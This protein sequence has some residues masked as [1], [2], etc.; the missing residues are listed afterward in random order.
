MTERTARRPLVAVV[1]TA[2][3]L[4]AA[5]AGGWWAS[6]QVDSRGAPLVRLASLVPADVHTVNLT[7]WAGIRDALGEGGTAEQR[8]DLVATAQTRDLSSRSVVSPSA[9]LLDELFGWAP[10][11]IGWEAFVQTPTGGALIIS[12]PESQSMRDLADRLTEVGYERAGGDGDVQRWTIDSA[13]LRAAGLAG[14]GVFTRLAVVPGERIAVSAVDDASVDRVLAVIDGRAPALAGEPLAA[15]VLAPL[16][17][18]VTVLA[19]TEE[20]ACGPADPA[21]VG[22]D[23]RAQADAALAR[24]GPLTPYR[25][26]ARAVA[27]DG[28]EQQMTFAFGFD[29]AGVAAEQAAVRQGLATGPFIGRTGRVD[30]ALRDGTAALRGTTA[31]LTF[32]RAPDSAVL[33]TGTGPVLFAA[34]R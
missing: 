12:L 24:T 18:A 7:D 16:R 26:S 9:E 14:E 25:W 6:A 21:G 1:V 17:K 4:V 13:P 22:E 3:V 31:V 29:T 33:M 20:F 32:D 15:D 5:L 34:C 28:D 23:A 10:W 11:S 27:D 19:Q 8:S 30:D 2:L